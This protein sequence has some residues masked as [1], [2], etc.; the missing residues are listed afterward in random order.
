[1]LPLQAATFLEGF[2]LP[3]ITYDYNP[4]CLM[5]SLNQYAYQTWLNTTS[6]TA[7]ARSQDA[8]TLYL[9]RFGV[10]GATIGLSTGIG[11]TLGGTSSLLS[12]PQD[13][14]WWSAQAMLDRIYTSWQ[15]LHPDI[16]NQIDGTKTSSNAPP[17]INVTLNSIPPGWDYLEP[18]QR[19]VGDLVSTI[20][21]PLCYEYDSLIT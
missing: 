17:S 14:I 9:A 7:A 20:A 2:P 11:L 5:R 1:M 21:G 8:A 3:F 15:A 6:V 13:P 16:A 12:S 19:Q 4:D 18:Q 10:T